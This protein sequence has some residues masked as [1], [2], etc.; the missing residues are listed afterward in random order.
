M[1][2]PLKKLLTLITVFL[3]T[4]LIVVVINQTL[5]LA[6][7]AERVSPTL[8]L[9]VFWGLLAIYAA[10][11]ITPL[12]IYFSL[13]PALKPPV[14]EEDPQFEKHLNQLRKR[15]ARNPRSIGLPLNNRDQIE[16]ALTK[17]DE[18]ALD[19]TRAT[20]GKVFL[21]TAISQNG[22]LDALIVLAV[23]S[24]LVLDIAR[25]YHQRPSLRE[26]AQL[27]ANVAATAFIARELDEADLSEQ[28]QPVLSSVLGSAAGAVPGLQVASTLLVS[29]V[30]SGAANAFLS[31]RV[32]IIAQQYCRAYT[33]P[34]RATM[35][36]SATVRA[37]A[38]LGSIVARG[39]GNVSSAIVRASTRGVTGAVTDMGNRV[40]E[41][42][43]AMTDKMTFWKKKGETPS[44]DE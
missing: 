43:K 27:Y 15:L 28:V 34:E 44:I 6:E 31:L 37:L 2:S 10:C 21:S 12:W 8:G 22:S 7:F 40:K 3:A 13:P 4:A 11:L 24:R 1:K 33:R 26:L 39:S 17:L 38:M 25:I 14:S 18:Q 36:K 19:A 9:V 23:Q 20:A 41:T 16:F 35:R 30:A 32:G 29:S 5:Q 42:S